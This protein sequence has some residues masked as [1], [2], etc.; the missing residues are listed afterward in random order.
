MRFLLLCVLLASCGSVAK[1]E[2]TTDQE[3]K[4]MERPHFVDRI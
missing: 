3:T 2:I 1:K 4:K